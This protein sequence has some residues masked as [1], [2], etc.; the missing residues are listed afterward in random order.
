[1]PNDSPSYVDPGFLCG[2]LFGRGRVRAFTPGFGEIYIGILINMIALPMMG[3]LIFVSS[4]WRKLSRR[5]ENSPGLTSFQVA[6][7]ASLATVLAA[8]MVVPGVYGVLSRRSTR[9]ASFASARS[10]LALKRTQRR[11]LRSFGAGKSHCT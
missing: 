11:I 9:S 1:M 5:G 3:I 6:G 7:W 2:R 8:L 10:G 4:Q